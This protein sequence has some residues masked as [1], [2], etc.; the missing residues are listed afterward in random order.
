[1]FN[2]DSWLPPAKIA[3]LRSSWAGP[4]LEN[5]LPLLIGVEADFTPA[6]SANMGAPNKPVAV[7]LGLLILKDTFDLTDAEVV[8]HFEFDLQWQYA[9]DTS[10]DN[11]HVCPKTLYNFRQKITGHVG[12]ESL[13]EEL[14]DKIIALWSI[15]TTHHRIDSTHILSNMKILN[16]LGLFVKTIEQFLNKLSSAYPEV[17]EKLP[18]HF[19][20]RYIDREGYFADSKSSESRHRLEQCARDLWRLVNRFRRDRKVRKL[21]GYKKLVRL[22]KEQCLIST[23]KDDDGLPHVWFKEPARKEKENDE[24]GDVALKN[25]KEIASDTMQNP[26]DPDATY[27]GH[28][29]TGYKA[30]FAETCSEENPFQVISQVEVEGA[31]KSDQEAAERIHENLKERGH[32]PEVSYVD[33]GYV[34]GENILNA[35]KEGIDLK[36]PIGGKS[37][38]EE[39]V[40]I[41]DFEFNKERTKVERCPAGYEPQRQEQSRDGKSVNAYFDKEKCSGCPYAD[42]CPTRSNKNSRVLR[43]TPSQVACAQ[44]RKEQQTPEFKEEHKIRSGIEATNSHLKNDRGMGRLRV[45]GSPAVKLSVIFKVIAENFSR[46][47]KYVLR[48][49]KNALKVPRAVKV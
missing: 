19:G 12:I 49:S 32:T 22:L 27:S 13:F 46:V 40:P 7:L 3:R 10:P 39:K 18:R 26:S 41:G 44:R 5:V 15:K 43:F 34:S 47:V 6:Y 1:M 30:Q 8:E 24:L 38:D 14:T 35:E 31:H 42:K 17:Y 37:T 36:G 20:E 45:R 11:A 25:P 16:R 33:S 29:G 48:K 28:K 21:K 9:L 4:F 23:D 2:V